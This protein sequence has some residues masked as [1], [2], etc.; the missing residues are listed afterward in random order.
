MKN[1]GRFDDLVERIDELHF[2]FV[3][4]LDPTGSYSDAQYDDMRAFRLLVHS[5]IEKYLELLLEDAL[6]KFLNKVASW[7]AAQPSSLVSGLMA[8][9]ERDIRRVI[10]ENNGV[11]KGNILALMKP[12][13]ITGASLD[14]IWLDDMEAYGVVR[15]S[16]AHNSNRATQLLDPK[17]EQD[18]LYKTL[19]PELAKL[20]IIV[21][22]LT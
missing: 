9:L 18:L 6:T 7:Q 17:S 19:L 15:G 14:N 20:E 3:P 13:G 16:F 4:S 12:L 11:K 2:R 10:K 5:E 1:M 21:S 8:H 22:G